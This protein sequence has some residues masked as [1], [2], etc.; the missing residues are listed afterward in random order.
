MT[1]ERRRGSIP[2]LIFKERSK[3]SATETTEFAEIDQTG[4]FTL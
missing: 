2:G 3:I 4:V 1:W